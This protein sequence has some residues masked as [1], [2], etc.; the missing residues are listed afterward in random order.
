VLQAEML[1]KSAVSGM[2]GSLMAR[3]VRAVDF[4]LALRPTAKG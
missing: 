1:E 4:A 3:P 2:A